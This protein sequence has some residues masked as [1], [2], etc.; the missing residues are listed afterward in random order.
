MDQLFLRFDAIR[1]LSP[2]LKNY[3]L[4]KLVRKE[5][6][7]DD[8]ILKEG[9]IARHI[10]FIERGVVR[11]FHYY[12][13]KEKTAWIMKD[14]DFFVSVRSFFSQR[15]ARETIE[16]LEDC[17]LYYITYEELDKAYKDFW[18]FDRHGRVIVTYYYELSEERNEMRE[19]SAFERFKFL[20]E[21]QPDLIGRVP[22][23]LLASYLGMEPETFSA[24]KAKF[25]NKKK[26]K[27]PPKQGKKRQS[28]KLPK[29]GKR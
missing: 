8:I 2:D 23:K 28:K 10:Y 17:I 9:E 7:K 14:G 5:V 24:Q 26:E 18:E 20:M 12:R 25:A 22:Q 21:Y 29:R 1:K 27:T 16:A 15:P 6:K 11:S 13:G 4:M 19:L 3:L